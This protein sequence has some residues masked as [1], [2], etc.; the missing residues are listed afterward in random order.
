MTFLVTR[1]MSP[2]LAARVRA[3]VRGR[4]A[5]PVSGRAPRT[6]ALVRYCLLAAL[7]AAV[8]GVLLL[9]RQVHDELAAE[10]AAL[11]DAVRQQAARFTPEDHQALERARH[12]LAQVAAADPLD[13]LI[14][15]ELRSAA[16]LGATLTRPTLYVRGPQESFLSPEGLQE[17]AS[18]SS[19]DAFVLCL[20]EPPAAR[21]ERAI[22]G[23]TRTA[24]AGG[25][26]AAQATDQVERLH[27]A[28]VTA[29]LIAPAWQERV[30]NAP[31]RRELLQLRRELD[32]APFDAAARAL[33]SRQVL[34]LIDDPADT[35]GPTELDGERPH[36]VR[37][38]LV[39]LEGDRPLL[40]L[41][42]RV[43]PSWISEAIRAEY[44][45]GM[46]SCALALDVRR[47]VLGEGEE[48]RSEGPAHRPSH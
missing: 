26:R 3:S 46:D 15:D 32:R 12:W 22:L 4:R 45:R 14:V 36:P 23:R 2:E 28:L 38:G 9:R 30:E 6:V 17:S 33:K 25:K 34:F 10:R 13:D 16:G 7:L 1:K 24:Y 41:R 8:G 27:A 47:D 29:P 42:R 5:R 48:E 18:S 44:A 37:V 35:A 11:L 31:G 43:D 19:K 40:L 21:S 39:D 20:N